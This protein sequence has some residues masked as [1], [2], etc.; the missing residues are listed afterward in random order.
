MSKA[1]AAM[2][3]RVRPATSTQRSATQL[4]AQPS[5]LA[6]L[7]FLLVVNVTFTAAASI[8][9]FPHRPVELVRPAGTHTKLETVAEGI[10]LLASLPGP[11]APVAVVGPYRSGKLCDV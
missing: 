6:V 10:E 8:N 3:R 1:A 2:F 11:V 9:S 4:S 5:P 7:V